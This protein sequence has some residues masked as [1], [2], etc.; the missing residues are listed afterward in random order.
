MRNI[1]VESYTK[2][3]IM[4]KDLETK[5]KSTSKKYNRAAIKSRIKMLSRHGDFVLDNMLKRIDAEEELTIN[6]WKKKLG[7]ML[8]GMKYRII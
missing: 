7:E 2:S 1:K 6:Q 4:A 5:S 8:G 3:K